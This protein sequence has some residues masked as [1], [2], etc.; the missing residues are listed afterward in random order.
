MHRVCVCVH[1]CV[2]DMTP[3]QWSAYNGGNRFE[4]GEVASFPDC[5]WSDYLCDWAKIQVLFFSPQY[6]SVLVQLIT[7]VV[8]QCVS[9]SATCSAELG[10]PEYVLS[11]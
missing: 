9:Q 8:S 10:R 6:R 7:D 5:D 1:A 4:D 11:H 3:W 2:C